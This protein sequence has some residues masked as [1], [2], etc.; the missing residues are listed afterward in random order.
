[1]IPNNE[2]YVAIYSTESGSARSRRIVAWNDRGQPM[3]VGDKGLV[4]AD[5][6]HGFE[7]VNFV[8]A[9]DRTAEKMTPH[10]VRAHRMAAKNGTRELTPKE[11]IARAVGDAKALYGPGWGKGMKS[12][13][14]EI[15]KAQR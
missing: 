4:P 15:L 14:E 3:V 1:M 7:S 12:D 2:P 6:L 11:V 10:Q 13:L 8:P 9:S 5:S